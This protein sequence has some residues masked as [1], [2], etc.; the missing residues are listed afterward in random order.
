[1]ISRKPAEL[2]GT[3]RRNQLSSLMSFRGGAQPR[4]GNLNYIQPVEPSADVPRE[5]Y[6][7]ATSGLRLAM[8]R[9]YDSCLFFCSALL[10][11]AL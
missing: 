7:I 1:M 8:T 10:R 2:S 4:R 11:W 6:E 9:K 3:E 5:K